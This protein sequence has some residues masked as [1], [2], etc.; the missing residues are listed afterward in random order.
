MS[1]GITARSP[2]GDP[3]SPTDQPPS[4]PPPSAAAER[5]D[6][7]TVPAVVW[8]EAER[9]AGFVR[10]ARAGPSTRAAI[11]ALA[12]EAGVSAATLYKWVARYERTGTT[13]ALVPTSRKG[14]RQRRRLP[15]PVAAI[16]R[17]TIDSYYL[18]R[19][20]PSVARTA[21]EVARRCHLARLRPPHRNTVRAYIAE[22]AEERRVQRRYGPRAAR[23]R[24]AP[25]PGA[26]PAE[27]LQGPLSVVQID[28][29]KLDVIVVDDVTRGPVGRPWLTLAID[30]FSRMVVGFYVALDPPSAASVGLC[31]AQA[32]LPKEAWLRARGLDFPWPCAGLPVVV[33]ADNAKEFRGH[34]L[35]RACQEYGITL[36][37]RL[38]KTPRYGAHVERLLGTTLGELHTLPGTTFSN[39]RER[40]D[41]DA[42]GKAVFTLS[43]LELYLATFFLG[44]YHERV[45][46]TLET[47]PRLAY[48]RGLV[49]D[50]TRPALGAPRL[51]SDAPRLRLDFLPYVE[52][53]VRP[54]GVVVDG[55]HYY[56]DVLRRFIHAREPQRPYARVK[57]LFRR[58]PRDVSVLHFWDPD[59]KQ[60]F[61]VPYRNLG[62]PPLSLWELRAARRAA[63]AAG[64]RE[65][66]EAAIFAAYTCLR[67]LE[68]TATRETAKVRRARQR[69]RQHDAARSESRAEPAP[70][71]GPAPA[72]ASPH[73]TLIPPASGLPT[74]PAEIIPFEIEELGPTPYWASRPPPPRHVP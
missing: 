36:A 33:H 6:L 3:V 5:P 4:L 8:A 51:P 35:G 9:R 26:F 10:R 55:V 71:V 48:E 44:V 65:V 63:R 49:G 59:L 72:A 66:N 62:R 61:R 11:A 2:G 28:H 45:H 46:R 69:R 64:Q 38:V 32:I 50:G 13:S 60:Y 25:E 56:S 67:A 41:Y 16:V 30:V 14:K 40:D 24:Y 31:L 15:E 73:L 29:T 43:E 37:W 39:P 21:I 54:D 34:A 22:I 53:P 58:D 74:P 23:E 1:I 12:E 20:R 19:E 17:E 52:R 70:T 27:E 47:T 42:E 18:T 57:L 7:A 68:E